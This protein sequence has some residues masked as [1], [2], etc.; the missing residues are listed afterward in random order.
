[1]ESSKSELFFSK[2]SSP[3]GDLFALSNKTHLLGLHF[4]SDWQLKKKSLSNVSVHLVESANLQILKAVK[5]QLSEYFAGKRQKF[6]L[7]I[8]V[9][10]TRFQ[11]SAW[12][13]LLKIPH[14]KTISYLEQAKLN[15]TPK[16]VR[17]IGS[18]NGKNPICIIIPC[19][20]V[21]A[22]NGRLGGYSGG[23]D[24]KKILLDLE[25]FKISTQP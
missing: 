19:H 12:D 15:K 1:M 5:K 22:A 8:S 2:I 6:D 16:A 11:K 23:L 21:I 17:A 10:G 4:K 13:S 9:E 25:G 18:A 24:K 3:V 20:R 14:G 7:K